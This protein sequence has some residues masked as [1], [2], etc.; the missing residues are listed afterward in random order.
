VARPPIFGR[1]DFVRGTGVPLSSSLTQ[2]LEHHPVHMMSMETTAS[3]GYAY[4]RQTEA[5]AI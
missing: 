2:D 1:M 4:C 3:S 5:D